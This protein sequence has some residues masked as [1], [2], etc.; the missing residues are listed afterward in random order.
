MLS[1]LKSLATA[2]LADSFPVYVS[3][4]CSKQEARPVMYITVRPA[5]YF[6]PL[7]EYIGLMKNTGVKV[8]YYS[9]TFMQRKNVK[10][11]K[12]VMF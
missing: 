1:R 6:C 4:F 8:L 10:R 5:P 7:C 9:L 12:C 3:L 11:E 2:I